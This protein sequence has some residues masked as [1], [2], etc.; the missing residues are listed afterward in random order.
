MEKI[1]EISFGSRSWILKLG[2][3]IMI[4]MVSLIMYT[5]YY[6][7]LVPQYAEVQIVNNVENL[8]LLS[9]HKLINKEQLTIGERTFSVHLFPLRNDKYIIEK[10]YLS[11]ENKKLL[12]KDLVIKGK[13]FLGNESLFKSLLPFDL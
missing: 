5:G 4:I 2:S 3:I 1:N 7:I 12:T 6:R 13:I 8:F 11:N 10:N 9:D